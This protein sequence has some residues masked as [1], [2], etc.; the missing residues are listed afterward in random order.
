MVDEKERSEFFDALAVTQVQVF[1]FKEGANLGHIKGLAS[2]VLNDQFMVRGLRVM[3]G[4]N[5]MFVSYPIDPF[6][7]GDGV[8]SVCSPITRALR[9]NIEDAVLRKYREATGETG[10]EG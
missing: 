4:L 8:R 1:P 5:G 2:V 7:K 3:E 6:Y 9:E 10:E